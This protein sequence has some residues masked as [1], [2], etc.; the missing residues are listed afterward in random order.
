[1]TIESLD[2]ISTYSIIIIA[3]YI[4]V[5]AT[6]VPFT[7]MG[8]N[9]RK[10]IQEN[11]YFQHIL[12]FSI[13]FFLIVLFNKIPSNVPL[14]GLYS[15]INSPNS[16]LLKL[17][18]ISIL[19]YALFI[20]SSRA[21]LMFTSIILVL[22]L[23]LFI[24]NTIALKKKALEE[25]IP[26]L[27]ET[28][29]ALSAKANEIAEEQN[30]VKSDF[31]KVTADLK[32]LEG[33]LEKLSNEMDSDGEQ[34]I[35]SIIESIQAEIKTESL[36]LDERSTTLNLFSTLDDLLSDSG[37]KK[38]LIDKIIPTLN[39]RIQEISERLEFKFQFEFDSDFNP[40]ISYLGM[41]VSPES[42]SS[43]QRKKM[44]LIVLLAFIEIIKM[45]HSQMNV[46]F[47]D[48]IFSSLDKNNV[49]KAIEI[50]KEYAEKYRLTIFVVSHESL[51][52]EFF[53][54][55]ILVQ[56]QDHF[57]EMKITKVG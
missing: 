4:A 12:T 16:E 50:L 33:D 1:M 54:Y 6:I 18:G 42:L 21:S 39:S 30:T 41:E 32:Q 8:E 9:I 53:N 5:A 11:P 40:I 25:S 57:S 51:P 47:L 35:Q 38:T 10:T 3:I 20:M 29:T 17:F 27:R 46:L 44:N 23:I 45:K 31:F 56:T 28:F 22:L 49:Y 52:E 48:E 34:A 15:I 24:L 37:I 55:R 7:V 2:N 26:A 14:N 19:I 36:T 43:G 13:I